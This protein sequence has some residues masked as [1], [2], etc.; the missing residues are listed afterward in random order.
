MNQEVFT[1]KVDEVDIGFIVNAKEKGILEKQKA[2]KSPTD[3]CDLAVSVLEL[4]VLYIDP[5]L[6]KASPP[7][8]KTFYSI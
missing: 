4:K 3:L 6:K 1:F 7:M 5:F 2:L 8:N